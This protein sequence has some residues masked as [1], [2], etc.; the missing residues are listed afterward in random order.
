MSMSLKQL[1]PDGPIFLGNENQTSGSRF[2]NNVVMFSPFLFETIA[3]SIVIIYLSETVIGPLSD[4]TEI[5]KNTE[6]FRYVYIVRM[7][8][9]SPDGDLITLNIDQIAYIPTKEKKKVV[10]FVSPPLSLSLLCY[11]NTKSETFQRTR[12]RSSHVL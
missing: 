5:G 7:Y 9:F 10:S 2:V 11:V 12:T 3:G 4:I 1:R 8:I 6:D